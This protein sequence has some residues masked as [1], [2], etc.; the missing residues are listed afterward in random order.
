MKTDFNL[1]ICGLWQQ[2]LQDL[3]ARIHKE[4]EDAPLS[5]PLYVNTT[6][7][8]KKTRKDQATNKGNFFSQHLLPH[9]PALVSP[10]EKLT[11]QID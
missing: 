10:K 7:N 2:R 3:N 4:K 8:S 5:T 1:G 6:T 9:Q 11:G